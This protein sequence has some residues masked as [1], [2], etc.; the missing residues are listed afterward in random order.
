MKTESRQEFKS[1]FFGEPSSAN[2]DYLLT[3]IA[4]LAAKKI[5]LDKSIAFGYLARIRQGKMVQRS[6][7]QLIWT[8]ELEVIKLGH[9]LSADQTYED[10][11]DTE[12]RLRYRISTLVPTSGRSVDPG[13]FY[14][15]FNNEYLNSWEGSDYDLEVRMAPYLGFKFSESNKLELGLDYRLDSFINNSSRHRFWTAINWYLTL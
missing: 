14:W 9:R 1:G 15:K 4:L 8:Q 2:Y 11:A 6:I 12:F 5:D 10:G 13:E 7:Q 3:D